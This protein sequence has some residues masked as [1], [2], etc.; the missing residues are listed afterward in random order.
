MLLMC[1]CVCVCVWILLG[2]RANGW[3]HYSLFLSSLLSNHNH[4]MSRQICPS[5]G[6][7]HLVGALETPMFAGRLLVVSFAVITRFKNMVFAKLSLSLLP[8]L[9]GLDCVLWMKQFGVVSLKRTQLFS[10]TR[11]PPPPPQLCPA[12][13]SLATRVWW[14]RCVGSL[15]L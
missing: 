5:L 15:I 10:H 1:V 3:H 9:V 13:S 12:P 4:D 11:L 2:A 6:L 7:H 8:T 14:R